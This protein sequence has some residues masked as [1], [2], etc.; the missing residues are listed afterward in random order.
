MRKALQGFSG[1][2]RI[3]E[4][5]TSNL[6]YADDIVLLAT[7]PEELQQLV[8]RV[9]RAAKE[10]N[11]LINATNN[12]CVFEISGNGGKLEQVDSSMYL[13]SKVTSVADC[14]CVM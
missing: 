4:R 8:S 6:R 1:R 3:S 5:T 2:F 14:V 11:T 7:S 13:G 9:E 10:Y 12:G